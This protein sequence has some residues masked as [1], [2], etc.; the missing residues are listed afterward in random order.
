ME[1]VE[2]VFHIDVFT[3]DTLPM[4]RLAQYLAELAKMFG[5]TEHTHF[6]KVT[7]GSAKLHTTVEPVDAPKVSSRLEAVRLG[8]GPKDAMAGKRGLEELLANDNAAGKLIEVETGRVVVPFI[9]RDRVKPLLFPPFREDTYIDGQLVSIGGRDKTAH[10]ILQDG[11]L[12][13]SG[14]T[15]SRELARELA[16]LLYGPIL[17]L[18]GNGRF[19]RQTDGIWKMSDF[20]TDRYVELDQRSVL[21]TL[22]KVRTIPRNGLMSPDAYKLMKDDHHDD[23][24]D[25]K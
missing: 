6:L 2:Y 10:A 3:P 23:G 9:G 13:H 12:T 18:F 7:S 25:D 14:V 17:R 5:H 20:R 16:P 15:M 19:E 22:A 21:E 1:P 11:E 8:D 24:E 4:N